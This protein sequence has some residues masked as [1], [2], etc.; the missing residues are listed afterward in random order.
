MSRA[1]FDRCQTN[2]TLQQALM[3]T[4][5]EADSRGVTGTPTFFVNGEKIEFHGIADL[6]TALKMTQ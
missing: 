4:L 2:G 6:M 5:K 3:D 1:A